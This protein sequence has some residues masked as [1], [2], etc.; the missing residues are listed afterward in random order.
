MAR[1]KREK[2]EVPAWLLWL[3]FPAVLT[4]QELAVHLYA[5]GAEGRFG[6]PILFSLAFGGMAD[7]LCALCSGRGRRAAAGIL[8][9]LGTLW[10]GAQTVYFSVFRTFLTLYSVGGAGQVLQFWRETLGGMTRAWLPLLVILAPGAFYFLRG[11]RLLPEGGVA[12]KTVALAAGVTAAVQLL[13]V[14]LV[15]GDDRGAVSPRYLYRDPLQRR[16]P[17]RAA[18]LRR[19]CR[20]SAAQRA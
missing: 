5:F 3:W 6:Y 16:Y 8:T 1:G 19:A 15:C 17:R 7:L 20:G 12:R 11:R 18:P 13:T 2:R 14:L 10:L 4:V 9:V